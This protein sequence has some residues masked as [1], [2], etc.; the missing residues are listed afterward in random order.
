VHD[1]A[2]T[3]HHLP[4]GVTVGALPS[5]PLDEILTSAAGPKLGGIAGLTDDEADSFF[6]AMGF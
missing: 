1:A 5:V 3:P 4:T 6:E 2:I